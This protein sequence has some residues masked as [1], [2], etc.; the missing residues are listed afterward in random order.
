MR[1]SMLSRASVLACLAFS[2]ACGG[3]RRSND[4]DAATGTGSDAGRSDTGP[5][6]STDAF[7]PACSSEGPEDSLAACSDGCDND[8]NRFADCNDFDC[9]GVR[10]DCPVDTQCG[11]P[12]PDAGAPTATTIADL[13]DRSSAMHPAPGARVS[14]NEAG[15]IALT[16]RILVGSATGGS[17]RS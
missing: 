17:S 5:A 7:V 11:A 1:T 12:R 2:L 9:C 14:V 15:M 16:G 4:M 10:T 3:G 13:Q 8:G 6:T